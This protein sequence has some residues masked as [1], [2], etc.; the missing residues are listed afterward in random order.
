MRTEEADWIR[1]GA[2]IIYRKE[3]RMTPVPPFE[4]ESMLDE[5]P[6]RGIITR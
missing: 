5:C 6:A 2:R 4:T 3:Q 1:Q